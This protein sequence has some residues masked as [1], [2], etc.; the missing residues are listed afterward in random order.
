MAAA[1]VIT[2]IFPPFVEHAHGALIG[3]GYG[4]IL[5]WPD[6]RAVTPIIHTQTILLEWAAIAIVA[7]ISWVLCQPPNYTSIVDRILSATLAR[8]DAILEAERIR[9]DAMIRAAEAKN[10]PM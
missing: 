2:V 8:N 4:F 9:A 6:G 10:T 3:H 7:A 1:I 5:F